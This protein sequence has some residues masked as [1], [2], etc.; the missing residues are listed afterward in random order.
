[1][2]NIPS[3]QNEQKQL[4][5]LAAQRELYSAAKVIQGWQILLNLFLP[6]LGA[7]VAMKY[8]CITVY[9]ALYGIIIAVLDPMIFD[10]MI[11]YR[12]EKAAKIQELF[13]CDILGLKHSPLKTSNDSMVEDVLT[14][15]NA[16]AKISTN[17]EKIKDWYP[18]NIGSLPLKIARLIC[19]RTNCYWDS[20]LRERFSNIIALLGISVLVIALVLGVKNNKSLV[21]MVLL[22][23]ILLPFFQ[24]CIK[25]CSDQKDA[26]SRL[27]ELVDYAKGIWENELNK[28]DDELA[29]HSRRLQDEIYEHRSK[30]PLILDIFYKALR[31]KDEGI[32]NT[33]ADAL[34]ID[35]R[36]RGII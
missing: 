30:S 33:T 8:D 23:S 9:V 25:Q 27:T 11:S 14:H 22:G 24:Y 29:E 31:T 36:A 6:L 16:H 13:D 35:A 15:Y 21:D 4:E 32:M 20:R 12:K 7:A 2:N 10:K 34:I 17:I 1:M 26:A 28:S 5:R 18:A 19:Q 3:K